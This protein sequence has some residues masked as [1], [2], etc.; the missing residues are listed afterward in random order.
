MPP[1]E[2]DIQPL[3]HIFSLL[4]FCFVT[5]KPGWS[6]QENNKHVGTN[7]L[8]QRLKQICLQYLLTF[9][10]EAMGCG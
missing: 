3:R 9:V 6:F 4:V 1:V 7:I 10:Y 5:D 2:C 8:P